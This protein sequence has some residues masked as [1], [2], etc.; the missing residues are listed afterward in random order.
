MTRQDMVNNI[1]ITLPLIA[2]CLPLS[3]EHYLK[4]ENTCPYETYIRIEGKCIDISEQGLDKITL[5]L[6]AA[7][8]TE[9]NKEIESV[10][11]ELEELKEEVAEFC[12]EEQ[13]ETEVQVEIMEDMCQY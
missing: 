9:V 6:G 7:H 4:A 2:L 5:E 12:V 8:I 10:S 1:K 3:F 13:P 11:Q